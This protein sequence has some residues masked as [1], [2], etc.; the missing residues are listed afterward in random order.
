MKNLFMGLIFLFFGIKC[1]G[2]GT[3]RTVSNKWVGKFMVIAVETTFNKVTKYWVGVSETQNESQALQF[4][5]SCLCRTPTQAINGGW[6]GHTSSSDVMNIYNGINSG[7]IS[8][9]K[10]I[11][12]CF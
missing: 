3:V 5:K 9:K 8:S 1:F 12:S 11:I 4:A 6:V 7:N 2:Q 10:K